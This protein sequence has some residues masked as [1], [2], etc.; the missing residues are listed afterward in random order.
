MYTCILLLFLLLGD[1]RLWGSVSNGV[2]ILLAGYF[3]NLF[4]INYVFYIFGISVIGFILISL[5]T[6]VVSND[7]HHTTATA[8]TE[9]LR[10]HLDEEQGPLLSTA[11]N[12][13]RIAKGYYTIDPI[14]DYYDSSTSSSNHDIR[15]LSTTTSSHVNALL[16]GNDHHH[17]LNLQ[18]TITSQAARDVHDEANILLDQTH[19]LPSL[20]LALSHIP[21]VDTSLTAFANINNE[22]DYIGLSL[23]NTIFKSAK[24]WT[25]LL[26]TLLFGVFYSMIAQF[27]FLFLSQD[28]KLEPSVIGWTGPLGGITE[29][30]TFYVSRIVSR[31]R[32]CCCCCCCY[33]LLKKKYFI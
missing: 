24:V 14:E 28:L 29:V 9:N 13:N 5:C 1:Q 30:S 15:R 18:R 32:R 25:F 17:L 22:E 10:M 21:T 16:I 4:G 19:G 27:L 6:T 26:M 33:R 11:Q 12:N 8:T 7:N 2:C 20:G 31:R 3:I 23:R